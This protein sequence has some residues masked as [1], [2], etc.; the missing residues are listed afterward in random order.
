MRSTKREPLKEIIIYTDGACIGN[1]GPGGWAAVLLHG[2]QRKEISGGC[3]LTTN[4]RMEMTA[5][6]E[7][8]RA[9]EGRHV[10]FIYTDSRYLADAMA[11]GWAKKWRANGWRRTRSSRAL[12]PDLWQELLDLCAHHEV[13]FFWIPGH[14]GNPEN[15]R[16]DRLSVAAAKQKGLPADT[17]YEQVQ[18]HPNK[19]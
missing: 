18:R 17:V 6:I 19:P 16:C 2:G 5:A 15:S 14:S 3:R 13:A 4:N 11:K 12:N 10:A 9:L 7:A 8:L 1:P